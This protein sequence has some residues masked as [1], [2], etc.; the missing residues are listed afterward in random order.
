MEEDVLRP[1][2]TGCFATKAKMEVCHLRTMAVVVALQGG[3]RIHNHVSGGEAGNALRLG[4]P[5]GSQVVV[6]HPRSAARGKGFAK[7]TGLFASPL[8][9]FVRPGE[10]SRQDLTDFP[11]RDHRMQIQ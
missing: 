6:E 7:M 9:R 5:Y 1:R 11:R 2:S 3:L 10:A 8:H 4:V